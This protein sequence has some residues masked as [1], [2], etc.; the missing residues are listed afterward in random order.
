MFSKFSIEVCQAIGNKASIY[1]AKENQ[2]PK[3]SIEN[4]Q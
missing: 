4:G 2:Q 1:R 3:L